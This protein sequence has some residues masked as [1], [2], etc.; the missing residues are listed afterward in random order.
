[1]PFN[2]QVVQA[3]GIKHLRTRVNEFLEAQI[4]RIVGIIVF[5][6]KV[7]KIAKKVVVSRARL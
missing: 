4:Y 7:V 3:G 2:Q 5:L 1:M 6:L